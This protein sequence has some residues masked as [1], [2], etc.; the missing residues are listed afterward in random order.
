MLI[1]E[2][3]KLGVTKGDFLYSKAVE[4]RSDRT[5]ALRLVAYRGKVARSMGGIRY[6]ELD[7]DKRR[8]IVV[9]FRI[10]DKNETGLTIVWR[11]LSDVEAPKLKMPKEDIVD[12][13]EAN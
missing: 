11:K 6:N 10:V 8:D 7:F 4:P 5:Y 1:D 9:V 2:N 13:N 12:E 3:F